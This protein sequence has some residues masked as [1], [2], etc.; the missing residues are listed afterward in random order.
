M[1]F[2][3][4]QLFSLSPPQPINQLFRSILPLLLHSHFFSNTHAHIKSQTRGKIVKCVCVDMCLCVL[5]AFVVRSVCQRKPQLVDAG[6]LWVRSS[7][8]R[9]GIPADRHVTRVPGAPSGLSP[10]HVFFARHSLHTRFP[11]LPSSSGPS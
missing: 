11:F 1:K 3:S 10:L 5:D 6:M 7:S 8:P 2:P 4:T 9:R